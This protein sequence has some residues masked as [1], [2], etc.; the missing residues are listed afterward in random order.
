MLSVFSGQV[1]IG[2]LL[3][4][5]RSGIEVFGVDDQSLGL[6]SDHQRAIVALS[7]AGGAT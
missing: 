2:T 4:R 5:G 3:S 6:F 1:Y 7:S